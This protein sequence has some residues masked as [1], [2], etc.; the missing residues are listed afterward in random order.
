MS[1]KN[2]NNI[3]VLATHLIG[4][5]LLATCITHSLRK[6]YPN[7]KIDV[8]VTNTGG[9]LAFLDNTDINDVLFV[10]LKPN[11]KQYLT[12][13][14]KYWRKYDLVVNDRSSDRSAIYSFIT[15]NK[16]IGVIDSR[17]SSARFKKL[18]LSEYVIES[19]DIEHRIVR[20]LRILEPL[21][22]KKYP[23][24]ISPEDKN[25]NLQ[26][27]FDLPNKYIVLHSPSSN[28]IKQWPIR[29]WIELVQKLLKKGYFLILTG[30]NNKREKEIVEA[31][32]KEQ[33]QNNFINL[34]G[35]ISFSQLST[36]IKNSQGFIGPDCGPAHLASSYHIPIFSIF[37]PTPVTMWSPWPYKKEA[38]TSG[39]TDR[40][41]TL[42]IDNITIFQSQRE[43]VP[44][45]G[46]V[47]DI[48]N[49]IY[50]SCLEDIKPEQVFDGIIKVLPLN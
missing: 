33:K 12:F 10:E 1:K 9:K 26:R 44:C 50:S 23:V 11:F 20:N 8:L 18:L 47:C 3:L 38:N 16:R 30:G 14:K 4:D 39:F 46:K 42:T 7:A 32:I 2:Y 41:P 31:I 49:S 36:L 29:H 25:I 43:C 28:E 19:N 37:G 24:V 35:K 48:K 5:C 27:E 15:G 40:I 22:I 17:H 13:A 6:A 34:T 21:N 45:Y